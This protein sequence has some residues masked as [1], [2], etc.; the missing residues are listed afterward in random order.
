MIPP[1]PWLLARITSVTY[2]TD[3]TSV[4]VQNTSDTTPYTVASSGRIPSTANTVCRA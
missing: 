4:T 3:T 2:L 1:S